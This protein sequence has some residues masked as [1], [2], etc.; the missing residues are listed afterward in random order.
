MRLSVS[1]IARGVVVVTCFLIAQAAPTGGDGIASPNRP[2]GAK[3][4][5]KKVVVKLKAAKVDAEKW[6]LSHG[7]EGEVPDRAF[8]AKI[9]RMKYLLFDVDGDGALEVD[10]DGL[11]LP[12]YPFI[13]PIPDELLDCSGQYRIE[14]EGTSAMR[15]TPVG[16]GEQRS[17]AKSASIFTEL[18]IMSGL[19]PAALD[20]MA[21]SH[22][23][24]HADYL[25]QNNLIDNRNAPL[26]LGEDRNKKGYTPEGDLVAESSFVEFNYFD[27]EEAL[28]NWFA[29]AFHRWMLLNPSLSR[30][31]A[32]T[33]HG[34]ATFYPWEFGG[35]KHPGPLLHPPD[36]G[37]GIPPAFSSRGENPTPVPGTAWAKG[38]G[39]P[40]SVAYGPD[41]KLASASV[42]IAA[43]GKN[44]KGTFSCPY[45]PAT[46]DFPSN[47]ASSIFIPLEPLRK[48]TRYSVLFE[49]ENGESIEWSFRTAKR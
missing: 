23:D 41:S 42:R 40:I 39:Y 7:L 12:Q 37:V 24:L 34:A 45:E 14:F 25:E 11:A 4:R 35:P 5:D 17:L 30:F 43:N 8:T 2:H 44:V 9:K 21:C 38:C 22:C 26:Q 32:T 28:S 27:Y 6:I 18:R 13:V 46:D 19:R 47:S 29:T 1:R 49:Y 31:G 10:R 33:R 48:N 15:F 36:H 16:L 3:G 20:S